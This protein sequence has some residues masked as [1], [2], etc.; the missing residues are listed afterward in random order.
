MNNRPVVFVEA[1]ASSYPLPHW[2][3]SRNAGWFQGSRWR[4]SWNYIRCVQL[5]Y[6]RLRCFSDNPVNDG[7]ASRE[8]LETRLGV[9]N[10]VPVRRKLNA[11]CVGVLDSLGD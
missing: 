2:P 8:F 4:H 11:G 5:W 1:D 10:R 7:V 3:C 6:R 9:V